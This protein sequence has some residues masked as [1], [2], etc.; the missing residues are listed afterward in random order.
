M[1]RPPPTGS[2]IRERRLARGIKQAA[3][4]KQVGISASYLNLIEHDRRAIGGALLGRIA[5]ALDLPVSQLSP[6]A[7]DALTSSLRAAG[8]AQGLEGAVLDQA[9]E[10]ARRHP[11][12]ARAAVTQAET[13]AAHARTIEAMSDRLSHDPALAAALHEVLS[14]V[15]VVRS[16]ASILAGTPEIDPNWLRRFH[17]I[18]DADSRRLAQ[19][20][21]AVVGYLDRAGVGGAGGLLPAE[22]AA[23]ILDGLD[24]GLRAALEEGDAG[25]IS[26][27]VASVPDPAAAR[28]VEAQL[29]ADARD[30]ERLPAVLVDAAEGPEALVEAAQGDLGLV[31]RRIGLRAEGRGLVVCDA[32]GAVLRRRAV[33]GFALP[34]MGAGCPL[35]PLFAALSRPG[36]P[37]R[38]AIET[39][40]GARWMAHAIAT[41]EGPV[42]WDAEPVV[43]ATMLLT[44][45]DGGTGDARPVGPGCRTCPRGTCAARREPSVLSTS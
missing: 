23:R 8:A 32:A 36:Q 30:A 12:W 45:D 18:L 11:D 33:A 42:G 17:A 41:R 25:A 27:L 7:D 15:S 34:V 4:A 6:E 9:G 10:I 2:R 14:A 3:L 16:T 37:L 31:L 43:R 29:R 44:R 5:R 38:Q 21:E 20:A 40:D 26:D 19:G 13:V 22:V 24:D 35:W 39:P 28:L 1:T